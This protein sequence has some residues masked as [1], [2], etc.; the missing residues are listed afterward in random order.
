MK[1]ILDYSSKI[2]SIVDNK[3]CIDTVK[4]DGSEFTNKSKELTQDEITAVLTNIKLQLEKAQ[5][6]YQNVTTQLQTEIDNIN[7]LIS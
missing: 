2:Y 4:N 1:K 7:T 6:E 5:I 3:I